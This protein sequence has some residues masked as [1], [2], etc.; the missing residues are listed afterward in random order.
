MIL[1]PNE[2]IKKSLNEYKLGISKGKRDEVIKYL[3]YYSGVETDKYIRQYFDSDAFMEIPQYKT[4]I[5]KKFINKMSRL[6]TIGAKRNVNKK[7]DEMTMKKNFKMK[8]VEKMTKL[9]GSLAVGVFFEE[10]DGKE[11]FHYVPVYHFMPFFDKD[12]FEPYAITYPNF[13]HIFY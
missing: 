9:L 1:T 12:M 8:H 10:M 2:I 3:D 13:H 5:T 7:Y 4:N 6:Y 11:H